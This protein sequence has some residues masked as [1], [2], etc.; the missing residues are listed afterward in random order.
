MQSS[1]LFPPLADFANNL[2]K[3]VA[4]TLTT[5]RK[6]L[7]LQLVDYV[8]QMLQ[9]KGEVHLNFICTHNS[10]RSHIS[11]IWAAAGARHFKLS[12]V[13]TYS[14]GTE[15][16]AFQPRA[17]AAMERAGFQIRTDD[18]SKDN[19][20][21][22][23]LFSEQGQGTKAWS[24]RFDDEANP[25]ESFAAI[26]TCSDADQ[27]CPWVPGTDKR[28]PL[29]FEDPKIADGTP[30]ETVRYDQA[31]REIGRELL[32]VMREVALRPF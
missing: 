18:A 7:L 23:V 19:P 21:Y 6:E 17:I 24:K 9:E 31:V 32:W 26:M 4:E 8:H 3:G 13:F 22:S 15:A 12:N 5:E 25:K 1:V 20:I 27:N 28:I 29:T 10:R 11:Q 16:T 2:L 30:A 14:G